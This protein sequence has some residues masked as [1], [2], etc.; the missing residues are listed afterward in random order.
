[1][2]VADFFKQTKGR[3]PADSRREQI[4]RTA[5][6]LFSKKGFNGT[7]TKDIAASLGVSEATVFKYFATKDEL[8]QAILDIKNCGDDFHQGHKWH[9]NPDLIQ[10]VEEKNDEK[11]F[12]TFALQ[13]LNKHHENQAFMRMILFSALENHSLAECYYR[14]FITEIYDFFASYIRK[15]QEDGVFKKIEPKTVVR[16]FLGMLVHHSLNNILWDKSRYLLN[17]TNEQA[18]REFTE[19][20]LN[21]ICIKEKLFQQN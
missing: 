1:M 10:A 3:M 6:D 2:S 11:V 21:G 9:D 19:I 13:A 4:I 7:T 18:A 8:Y 20:L 5:F 14:G 16:A 17:I 15:R 12:Y